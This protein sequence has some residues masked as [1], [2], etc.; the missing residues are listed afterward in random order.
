MYKLILLITILILILV[1]YRSVPEYFDDY[2]D[3]DYND[4]TNANANANANANDNA[5]SKKKYRKIKLKRVICNIIPGFKKDYIGTFLPEVGHGNNTLVMT[6]S[7]ESNRWM[8]PLENG[9]VDDKSVIVDLTYD[10]DR[11]LMCVAMSMNDDG[12]SLFKI[13]KKENEDPKSKWI[14]IISDKNIRSII[15][16]T[17]GKLMGCGDDGQIYKK[18]T[19][20]YKKSEWDGPINFDKPMKKIFF[21]KDMYLLG[22]GLNDN[23]L[24]KKRGFFWSEELWDTDNVNNEEIF[25][26]FHSLDG[27]LI[28]SSHRGLLKQ[29]DANFMSPYYHFSE[30]PISHKKNKKILNFNDT[31]YF[32]TG[33]NNLKSISILEDTNEDG[34]E[35]EAPLK[36]ILEFKKNAKKV[37]SKKGKFLSKKMSNNYSNILL[38]NKQAKTIDKLE[39]MISKYEDANAYTLN[40]NT[41]ENNI[42][43]ESIKNIMNN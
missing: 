37:C 22:I 4:N 38:V 16:D 41:I 1:V 20:D 31:L 24:Y 3:N 30:I 34:L 11:H 29:K 12:E 2:N 19:D 9:A 15:F 17:D 25:D 28:A 21:D 8:G 5:K 27:R 13:Y 32:R 43:N 23:K 18:L 42:A 35:L 26:A 7:L 36:S 33:L 40:E 39:E 6:R 10:K 14:E